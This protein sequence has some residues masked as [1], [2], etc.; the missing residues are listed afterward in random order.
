M[1]TMSSELK[2]T[3]LSKGISQK[4]AAFDIGITPSYLCQLETNNITT[5]FKTLDKIC[6]Y[7]ELDIQKNVTTND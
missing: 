5:T 7:Y 1:K 6:M 2:N 4:R 3:R